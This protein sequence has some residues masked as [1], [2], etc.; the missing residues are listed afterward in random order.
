MNLSL[1]IFLSVIGII[2]LIGFV[3]PILLLPAL[4][5]AVIFYYLRVYYLKATRS[6]KRLE[7]VG[8]IYT[9]IY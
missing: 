7:G 9:M 1:Q 2:I 6:V 8:E 4:V 5:L 3:N